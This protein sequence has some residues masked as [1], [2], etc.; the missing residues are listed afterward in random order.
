MEPNSR[1]IHPRIHRGI[2]TINTSL[3]SIAITISTT[4]TAVNGFFK[5]FQEV[6]KCYDLMHWL[7]VSGAPQE[8]GEHGVGKQYKNTFAVNYCIM[9]RNT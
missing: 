1:Y 7:G 9:N 4:L 3:D 5:D 6:Q 8:N 2:E